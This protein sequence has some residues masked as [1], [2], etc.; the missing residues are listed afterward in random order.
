MAIVKLNS[1]KSPGIK[2][3]PAELFKAV[4]RIIGCEIQKLII[5]IGRKEELPEVW[6]ESI[7]VLIYKK[8]DNTDCITYRD[9]SILLTTYTSF[10]NTCSQR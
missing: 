8:G 3:I 2:Q 9:I 10:S 1:H 7:I 4:G 5:S 6:K